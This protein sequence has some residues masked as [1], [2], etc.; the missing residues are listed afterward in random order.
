MN[1]TSSTSSRNRTAEP[2]GAGRQRQAALWLI[3]LTGVTFALIWSSAFSVAKIIVASTP[4]FAVS[5]IRFAIASLLAAAIAAAMGQRLPRGRAAWRAI[6]ILGL[7]QNSLYL[8]L[9]FSAMTR[10]PA[11]L[12][13]IIASAMPLVVATMAPKLIGE[14]I[15][16]IKASGL[17]MGFAGVVWI[18]A[19]RIAGG[20]DLV[21]VGLALGGVLALSI[22][23]LTVKGGNFGT[24]LLMVVAC[25]MMVGAIGCVPL[26][27]AFDDITA[28]HWSPHVIAALTY[29]I[30]MPGIVATLL[31]FWLVK[32]ATAASASAFHFL[33]PIFGVGIAWMLLG[34]PISLRD[35]FGVALVAIGILVVNLGGRRQRSGATA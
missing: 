6:I 18:M 15:G 32:T 14:R 4:P 31:W 26:A 21:G 9:F 27:L 5:A 8:G 3:L 29:Q 13:A 12:S 16:P 22:A 34:E 10:I 17:A 35:G 30:I 24:G 23:T 11:G 7:C 25:Q 19:T 1:P 33:N 20:V 2:S 28:F